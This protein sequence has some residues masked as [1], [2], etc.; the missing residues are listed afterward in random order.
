MPDLPSSKPPAVAHV[1][2]NSTA[3]RELAHA[4]ERA[5]TLPGPATVRDEL[6]YLRV[7]RDRARLVR[8]AMRRIL[9]DRETDDHD[10]MIIVTSLREE[11]AQLGDNT[12]QHAPEPS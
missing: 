8:R 5:L 7:L 11:A 10:I 1:P 6:T 9:A 12:Y 4:A 2:P 3:L